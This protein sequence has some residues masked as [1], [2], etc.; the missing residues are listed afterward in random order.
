MELEKIKEK[1]I[2]HPKNEILKEWETEICLAFNK[3]SNLYLDSELLEIMEIQ[4]KDELLRIIELLI[5]K[6]KEGME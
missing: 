4:S 2:N 3:D 5:S 6:V 1:I